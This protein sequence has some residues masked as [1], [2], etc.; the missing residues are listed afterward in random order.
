MK[1]SELKSKFKN[2]YVIRVVAGVLC[3]AVLGTGYGTYKVSAAKVSPE[4]VN[5]EAEDT[6]EASEE[7]DESE[8]EN[9]IS[10]VLEDINTDAKKDA[11]KEETVYL[12]S[13]ADGTVNKTIVSDW[14]KNT[15]DA[16]VLEDASDLKDIEKD[17][18]HPIKKKR[19]IASGT[20]S[21]KQAYTLA[22][23]LTLIITMINIIAP[24]NK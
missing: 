2:K 8:V 5:E 21:I 19:P 23:I 1:F 10:E 7:S 6:E 13:G 9:A 12:I 11:G 16:A 14:L 24:I 17:R 3:I 20:I 18:K 4:D 22:A 15:D